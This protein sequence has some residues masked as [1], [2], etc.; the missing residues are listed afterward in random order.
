MIRRSLVLLLG[1]VVVVAGCGSPAPT[2]NVVRSAPALDTPAT[3]DGPGGTPATSSDES[4]VPASDPS[5]DPDGSVAT[6]FPVPADIDADVD[7]L[8]SA[9]TPEAAV[10]ATRTILERSGVVIVEDPSAVTPTPAGMY[11]P[12][13]ELARIAEEAR[14]A[15]TVSRVSF[16]DFASRFGGIAGLPP[17]DGLLDQIASL[18]FGVPEQ[19]PEAPPPPDPAG[20]QPADVNLSVDLSSYPGHLATVLTDWVRR[21]GAQHGSSEPELDALTSPS[22]YLQA[23]AQ[24]QPIPVD[25]G[26]T[27]AP[28][29]LRLGSLQL[30][31]LVAGMRASLAYAEADIAAA[32]QGPDMILASARRPLVPGSGSATVEFSDCTELRRL[33]DTHVPLSI[34]I[35]MAG[36]EFV[37]SMVQ[38]FVTGLLGA[39]SA[40]RSAVGPAFTALGLLFRMAALVML[41]EESFA[42]LRLQPAFIHKPTGEPEVVSATVRA[43]IPDAAWAAARQQRANDPWTNALRLCARLLGLP[44][45]SD[46][47]DLGPAIKQWAVQWEITRGLGRHVR[48]H[49]G[50]LRGRGVV[51]SRMERTLVPDT[52]HTGT[53]LV[54]IDVLPEREDDHP[55]TLRT[56]QVEVCARVVPRLRPEIVKTL[57]GAGMA[58][59]SLSAPSPVSGLFSLASILGDLLMSWYREIDTIEDCREMSVSYHV[60][61]HSPWR[62]T[63]EVNYVSHMESTSSSVQHDGWGTRPGEPSYGIGTERT[64]ADVKETFYVGGEEDPQFAG[65]VP[66]DGNSFV[67]GVQ[68]RFRDGAGVRFSAGCKYRADSHEEGGG[69]WSLTGDATGTLTLYPDGKYQISLYGAR[70]DE[71]IVLPGHQS[72]DITILGGDDC[73]PQPSE[74]DLTFYPTHTVP[75]GGTIDGQIDPLNPGS[76][77]AGS[78]TIVWDETSYTVIT[79]DINHQGPI[80]LPRH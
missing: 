15:A 5:G 71:E 75:P 23:F 54:G 59:K 72:T 3:T 25:L 49:E 76:R 62:G 74:D 47:V 28:D 19:L 17:N 11:L 27:F 43:G 64:D 37:K 24:R 78:Q 21:A 36:K 26:Q 33:F 63:V 53:D 29:A 70:E 51:A 32:E 77:L 7:A 61:E 46:L 55:G 9:T 38:G 16:A 12:S 13:L 30:T 57:L 68:N 73:V 42:E 48:L 39:A 35:G 45:T 34:P 79:W 52:D 50:E 67:H 56:D 20:P 41:Y 10:A 65:Y 60:P 58:G 6:A 1:L 18:D 14:S 80:R 66:L 8:F 40:V 4:P 22:L 44:V 31:I 2:P 69:G